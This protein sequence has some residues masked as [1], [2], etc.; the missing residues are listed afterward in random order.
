MNRP[1]EAAAARRSGLG[2]VVGAF[3][4][5]LGWRGCVVCTQWWNEPQLLREF[6]SIRQFEQDVIPNS[7]NTR[8]VFCQDTREGIGIYFCDAAGGKPRLL[9]EQKE[10][11]HSWKRFTML[12][13]APDDSL[14]ACGFPDNKRNQELILIFQ[15]RTGEPAG[16]V[17]ADENLYHLAWLSTNALAYS[18]R[19]CVRVVTRQANGSWVHTRYFQ[20]VAASIEDFTTV[21]ASLVAWRDGGGIWLFDFASASAEK[22]W[23][24][25]TNR[26]V[27]FTYSTDANEFLLNCSDEAGQYLSRLRLGAKQAIMLERIGTQLDYIRNAVW[28]RTAHAATYAWLTNDPAGSAFCI[29]T[30]SPDAPVTVP[31]HGGVRSFTLSGGQLFFLGYADNEPPGIWRYDLGSQAFDCIVRSTSGPLKNSLGQPATVRLMTNSLGEQRFYHLWTPRRIAP[32]KRYPLLLAQE[33]NTWFPCFQLAALCGCFAA[34]ADRPSWHTWNGQ[35]ERTWTEDV[36]SLYELMAQN[37]SVDTNRVYLYA[38][39]A[40]TFYLSRLVADRPALA[41]GAILF[42]PGALPDPSILQ[43]KNILI[44]AGKADANAI[45]RCPEFQDHAAAQGSAITLFFQ[46]DA[47]HMVASGAAERNRAS[48]LYQFLSCSR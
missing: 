7:A 5:V 35:H 13:W 25:T 32:N 24:A 28:S 39:S 19:T 9:C 44:V 47:G 30:A 33:H 31:W 12:G 21:S 41:K 18:S 29:K 11:G 48:R 27:E 34:V 4:L 40:E 46:D 8:L 3:V 43:D 26:L 2:L 22:I 37:P 17:V 1:V 10:K 23:E 36:G 15:G 14:F 6:D 42:S 20:D 38:C 45:K 16:Q